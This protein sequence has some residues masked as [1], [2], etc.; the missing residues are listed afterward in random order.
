[1]SYSD[2]FNK[3]AQS[4]DNQLPSYLEDSIV[5]DMPT[6][7]TSRH[8]AIRM[9]ETPRR[10]SKHDGSDPSVEELERRIKVRNQK[11]GYFN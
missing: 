11:R 9:W 6:V 4:Y 1:M 2:G 7:G 8:I 5:D 10:E 3:A